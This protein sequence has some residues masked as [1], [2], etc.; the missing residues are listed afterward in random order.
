MS[1]RAATLLRNRGSYVN[2]SAYAHTQFSNTQI[3]I[4]C[5]LCKFRLAAV[6]IS[7]NTAYAA[8]YT[9]SNQEEL[10]NAIN[11]ANASGD[12]N[13]TITLTGDFTIAPGALPQVTTNL[14]IDTA[15]NTLTSSVGNL[16]L[17]VAGGSELTFDGS[18]RT[19]GVNGYTGA[20]IKDGGG[21][22]N[23]TG[24]PSNIY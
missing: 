17:N 11:Q 7:G 4:K 15:G 9:A 22:L 10:V 2:F 16:I 21:T 14:K 13:S 6:T 19:L 18:I 24:G 12:G 3:V 1:R 20:I 5:I 8:N 23:I